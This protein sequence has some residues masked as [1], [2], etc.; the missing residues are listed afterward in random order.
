MT[1]FSDYDCKCIPPPHTE[2]ADWAQNLTFNDVEFNATSRIMIPG[3]HYEP[4]T[5]WFSNTSYYC[6]YR[7]G[8][9]FPVVLK[10]VS[11]KPFQFYIL[12]QP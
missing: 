10:F 4:E 1:K 12:E 8:L 3:R 9:V 5:I 11:V 7:D 2:I 6:I